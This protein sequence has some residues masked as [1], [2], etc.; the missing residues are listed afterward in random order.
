MKI[1]KVNGT[2]RILRIIMPIV[3]VITAVVF[4]P[5]MLLWAWISPLP[6]TI[7]EQPKVVAG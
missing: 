1:R 2:I 3:G 6:D 7:E 4:V 5:W